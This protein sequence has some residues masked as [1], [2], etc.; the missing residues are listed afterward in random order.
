MFR[1][2]S[3]NTGLFR[4]VRYGFRHLKTSP[5]ATVAIILSLVVGIGANT[6]VFSLID[7]IALRDLPVKNPRELILLKWQSSRLPTGVI[8]SGDSD[9]DPEKGIMTSPS[10]SF[11]TFREFSKQTDIFSSLFAFAPA[12][13][14]T[15]VND[16]QPSFAE[17][18][19]VSGGYFAGLGLK[20]VLGRTITEGD[21]QPSAALVTVIS[22]RYW[23]RQFG[24]SSSVIGRVIRLNNS[25]CIIIGVAPESFSG[26]EQ[27]HSPDL[28]LPLSDVSEVAPWGMSGREGG[29]SLASE[30][31]WCLMVGG[32]LHRGIPASRATAFLD[33]ALESSFRGSDS[34]SPPGK[35][36]VHV[37]VVSMRRGLH[38]DVTPRYLKQL[39]TIIAI[40]ALVLL[41][42]CSNIAVLLLAQGTS[43]SMEM[44]IRLSCGASRTAL[45]R[46]LLTESMVLASIGGSGGLFV[47]YWTSRS[48][49]RLLSGSE[50]FVPARFDLDLAVLAFTFALCILAGLLF[51]I[52]PALRITRVEPAAAMSEVPR[53]ISFP[54]IGRVNL[55]KSLVV[56]Q[57]GLCLP[58]LVAAG[59]LL[60]TLS[61]LE[62]QD[63][64]FNPNSLLTFAIDPTQ[65]G[66]DGPRLITLY[67]E[68]Q[69]RISSFAGIG[70]ATICQFAP[71]SGSSNNA[72]LKIEGHLQNRANMNAMWYPVGRDFFQTMGIRMLLGRDISSSD[73]SSSKR[74]AVV[75]ESSAHYFFGDQNP[76][77]RKITIGGGPA[78]SSREYEIV[79]VARDAKLTY[80]RGAPG[81][82]VFFPFSQGIGKLG[83]MYFIVKIGDASPAVVPFLR[84]VIHDLDSN[85]PIFDLSMESEQI[86]RATTQ[87]RFMA[88]LTT[89]FGVPAILL[90]IIGVYGI[91]S[92]SLTAR[93]GQI[94]V[95]IALGA[96]RADVLRMVMREC[97]ALIFLGIALGIAASLA[98]AK[99]ISAFLFGL[100]PIEPTIIVG[101]AC[102]IAA[103]GSIAGYL[104][105]RRISRID[106][107]ALLRYE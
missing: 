18:E 35:D 33:V 3:G 14:V 26:I 73:S 23:S 42:T 28:W 48:L 99:L 72:T 17:A 84:R 63:L 45:I 97:L 64:G 34:Q 77:G 85:L 82:Q 50:Q 98:S 53:G 15:V 6:T 49:L 54:R 31:W 91:T 96:D 40:A 20:Q 89:S 16:D 68:L 44:A 51:G 30:S 12:G 65:E 55:G 5:V 19:M 59:L 11:P 4:D 87:E 62:H 88:D 32:R 56:S 93:M 83:Q 29:Q 104:P 79:G 10:F 74:V 46:Q 52:F 105:A 102:L 69:N 94:G 9:Y 101:A 38:S 95:R 60:K 13:Q 58:V 86:K 7:L 57:I 27:G 76:I 1:A 47:S 25:P 90:A 106:P 80:L 71:L 67:T 37:F 103:V 41:I 92:Y 107:M 43:R 36:V 81:R 75:N 8:Q 78:A 2:S 61:N 100:K 70:G 24:R 22:Y 21:V 66:Y 39:F